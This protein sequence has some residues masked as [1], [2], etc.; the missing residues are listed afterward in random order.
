VAG[1][2]PVDLAHGLVDAA[3]GAQVLADQVGAIAKERVEHRSMI[4]HGLAPE[5]AEG[6][7]EAVEPLL[8]FAAHGREGFISYAG[9][10]PLRGRSRA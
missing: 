8:V 4:L 7:M 6:G 10:A 9:S 1:G 5:T 2:Q 3:H